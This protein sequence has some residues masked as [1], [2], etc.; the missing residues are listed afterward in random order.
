LALF[1]RGAAD[2]PAL[3]TARHY[4]GLALTYAGV[5]FF[6]SLIPLHYQHVTLEEALLRFEA[7]CAEPIS[8]VSLSD[9]ASNIVLFIPLGYLLTAAFAVDR[10]RVRLLVG[11]AVV[12]GCA[13]FSA[14]IEFTQLYFP[15]RVCSLNDM[16]AETAG[17][18]LG[19]LVWLSVGQP[20]T[21]WAR[22]D[23]FGLVTGVFPVELLPCCVLV[24]TLVQLLPLDLSL[25][26]GELYHKYKEGRVRL[27][28]FVPW[29]GAA[30]LALRELPNIFL[31]LP[32]GVLLSGQGA[33][34]WREWA[35][36]RWVLGLGLFL[37]GLIKL[38]QLFVLSRNSFVLDVLTYGL[39][40]LLGWA[41][42]VAVRKFSAARRIASYRVG[43]EPR[44]MHFGAA[45]VVWAIAVAFLNWHPFDF[46]R[47][48]DWA[49]RRLA[50]VSFIPF[51]D[52]W[53]ANYL[54]ALDQIV[55]RLALYVPVG[56]TLPL[57]FGWGTKGHTGIRVVVVVAVWAVLIEIG[58][59]FLPTRYPSLTDVLVESL[60]AWF[61]C[62]CAQ[63]LRDRA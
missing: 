28:S 41:L 15:P 50:D 27:A 21:A 30:D 11:G 58:Q 25:Q 38:L 34:R 37:V 20:L 17:G 29:P 16:V 22:R 51:A 3:F 9:W 60:G 10:P 49:T 5:T 59:A 55:S 6:A 48:L 57:A 35:G 33:P 13:M 53:S 39:A 18:T 36:W 19:A 26:P 7:V 14:S 24:L 44:R 12:A 47:D 32:I 2:R 52:Y 63:R 42:G 8:V 61:G 56:L 43:W 23:P 31:F 1:G 54:Q 45:L 46:S 4:L 62:L 40:I